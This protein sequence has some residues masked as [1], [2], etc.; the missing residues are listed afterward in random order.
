[1][2]LIEKTKLTAEA[3]ITC[4]KLLKLKEDK[5]L[6]P[7]NEIEYTKDKPVKSELKKVQGTTVEEGLHCFENRESAVDLYN[8][9]AETSLN[10]HSSYYV[11][12]ECIIPQGAKYYYGNFF[13]HNV[14][15]IA[16]G[17]A[18]NKLIIKDYSII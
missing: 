3:D 1:M 10:D 14:D 9:I 5:L 2:N 16:N 15:K 7:F 17:Y 6:S 18:A 8:N 11:V 4:Y 12:A 13:L